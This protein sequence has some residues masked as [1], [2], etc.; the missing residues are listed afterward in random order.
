M[1]S[2]GISIR[3]RNAQ[4]LC[5]PSTSKIALPSSTLTST[6]GRERS[7]AMVVANQ[8]PWRNVKNGLGGVMF[9]VKALFIG[10][11]LA[12]VVPAVFAFG[13]STRT[14]GEPTQARV[15]I[16]NHTPNEAVPVT[17][18]RFGSTPSVHVSSVDGSVVLP[19]RAVRQ[20]WEYRVASFEAS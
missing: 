11:V 9:Q 18:E 13:Q 17:I 5:M 12:F 3:L 4:S 7:M 10:L 1:C 16:Q 8:S 20:R 14:P 2:T 15:W 6:M 19:S